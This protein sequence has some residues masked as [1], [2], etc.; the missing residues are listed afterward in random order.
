VINH[1]GIEGSLPDQQKTLLIYSLFLARMKD[2]I[3]TEKTLTID[4]RLRQVMERFYYTASIVYVSCLPM[5]CIYSYH[6]R[7][8]SSKAIK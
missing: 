2:L 1:A 6:N 8:Y 4:R 5:F 7:F 3:Y